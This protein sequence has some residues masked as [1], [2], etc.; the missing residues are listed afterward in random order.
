MTSVTQIIKRSIQQ[1]FINFLL[2][3]VM[4]VETNMNETE[5]LTYIYN[6]V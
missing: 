6:H 4:M 2:V 5:A 3:M 1:T